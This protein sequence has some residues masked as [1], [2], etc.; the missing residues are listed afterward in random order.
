MCKPGGR[1]VYITCS[2]LPAENEER[3]AAFLAAMRDFAPL[4]IADAARRG[5]PELGALRRAAGPGLRL[6]PLAAGRTGSSLPALRAG[7]SICAR[8]GRSSRFARFRRSAD[9][10]A[11]GIGRTRALGGS[12]LESLPKT[13]SGM[14]SMSIR[15][16][17]HE[18]CG[19]RG[20]RR[21]G[22]CG[23]LSFINRILTSLHLCTHFNAYA[24]RES[25][26]SREDLPADS[27]R[28]LE[29]S[30]ECGINPILALPGAISEVHRYAEPEPMA[31][32]PLTRT[33]NRHPARQGADRR[34]R[35]AGDA[36][37]RP[38]RP[39][40]GVYCEIA[41]FQKAEAAFAELKPKAVILS[42]GPASVLETARRAPRRRLQRACR[43]S[44]SATASRRMAA[45]LGGEVESR[46][47]P[48][49]RPRR[50]RGRR[51]TPAARRR[52]GARRRLYGLDEPRRPRDRLPPGF[53]TH[54]PSRP[55][56]RS[57][58]RRRGAPLLR[59]CSSIPKSCTRRDGAEAHR[60]FPAQGRRAATATGPWRA[61]RAEAIDD[62]PRAGR[63]RAG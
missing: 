57:R 13:A 55:M 36:A 46:P 33:E 7:A 11:P 41:P 21:D 38:P 52:L 43:C 10:A 8:A 53:S 40:G 39:R 9:E 14:S 49:I 23:T 12:I 31:E 56:R 15:C 60:E 51:R 42:G 30:V 47:S 6:S 20:T 4:P 37:D 29:I 2:L 28:S 27:I 22:I 50:S 48:R 17:A 58:H 34:F 62:D 24:L 26:D 18:P 19:A 3:M 32:D 54:R 59:R 16:A 44:A 63:R 25:Q 1:L 61:F 45:Q 35:L 5:L